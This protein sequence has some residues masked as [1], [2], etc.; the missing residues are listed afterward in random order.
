MYFV[1]LSMLSIRE[2]HFT[3]C[4]TS[5]SVPFLYKETCLTSN[6]STERSVII[7]LTDTLTLWDPA[8]M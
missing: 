7:E 4:R 5:A 1:V 6:A 3:K 2:K 8:L